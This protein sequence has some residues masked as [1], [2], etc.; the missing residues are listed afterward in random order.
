MNTESVNHHKLINSIKDSQKKELQLILDLEKLP[1]DNYSQ[2]VQRRLLERM[3]KNANLR[4]NE[5]RQ[6]QALYNVL[7]RTNQN[8]AAEIK[9]Q[10]SQ[11]EM[12]NESLQKEKEKM[13][14]NKNINIGNLRMS[15]ISTYY[16]DK[17]RA[18]AK[19]VL[20]V[21]YLCV[22][23]L[24]LAILKSRNIISGNL[25]SNLVIILIVIS[26]FFIIPKILDI[27]AR[28]NMVFSEYDFST[29]M[30]DGDWG[31]GGDEKII[32][33]SGLNLECIGPAC[34]TAG[35]IYDNQRELCIV[36]GTTSE[37]FLSGQSS[38]QNT[39]LIGSK[40]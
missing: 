4:M 18:Q 30:K 21:I 39:E 25:M 28:N 22:P 15:E 34:C 27:R 9:D 29:D 26:L 33:I 10:M 16:S 3:V 8:A 5:F 1:N 24:L 14:I 40:I 32:D 38:S 31:D 12:V 11:I 13:A 35:M 36:K 19:I 7:S 20:Y 37:S 17:Y 23:L 2:E 6:L